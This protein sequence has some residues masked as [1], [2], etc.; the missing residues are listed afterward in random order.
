M[1]FYYLLIPTFRTFWLSLLDSDSVKFVGL[2]NYV[3]AF[4]SPAML[5]SFWRSELALP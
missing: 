3:Y 4:T 1:V 5:E 2:E